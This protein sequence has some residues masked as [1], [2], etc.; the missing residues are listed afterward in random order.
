[1]IEM[2]KLARLRTSHVLHL[3]LSVITVGFWIPVWVIVAMSNAIERS[4]IERKLNED[5]ND[6]AGY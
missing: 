1:M 6:M 3:L 4:K 2:D 5:N